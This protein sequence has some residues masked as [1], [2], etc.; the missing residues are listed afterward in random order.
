VKPADA[1]AYA[2]VTRDHAIAAKGR[3]TD[4][5]GAAR[6]AKW[7]RQQF[8]EGESLIY[9]ASAEMTTLAFTAA[10]TLPD[11]SRELDLLGAPAGYMVYEAPIGEVTGDPLTPEARHQ[12]LEEGHARIRDDGVIATPIQGFMWQALTV[13]CPDGQR[14]PGLQL[15]WLAWVR[16]DV[17]FP[18]DDWIFPFGPVPAEEDRAMIGDELSGGALEARFWATHLLMGQTLTQVE[19]AHL[20][21]AAVK[22]ARRTGLPASN[23]MIVKLRKVERHRE[24]AAEGGTEWTHRWLVGGHWRQQWYPSLGR[25]RPIWIAAHTKPARPELPLVVK[26]RVYAWVR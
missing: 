16:H 3:A 25:H 17:L 26:E 8:G 11:L 20:D 1:L 2:A 19:P 4:D 21:R 23:V 18:V 15:G 5:A 10:A 14:R 22:R 9:F 13:K 6:M 7:V 24:Q 12:L